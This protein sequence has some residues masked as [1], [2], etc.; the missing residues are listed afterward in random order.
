MGADLP[1]FAQGETDQGNT[2]VT[3]STGETRVVPKKA[4]FGTLSAGGLY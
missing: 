2:T 1:L 4:D 3:T